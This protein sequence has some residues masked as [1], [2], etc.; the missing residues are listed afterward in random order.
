L[1]AP[2]A[3]LF[4]VVRGIS[5][6]EKIVAGLLVSAGAFAILALSAGGTGLAHPGWLVAYYLVVTTGELLLS[7][8]GLSLVSKLSPPRWIGVLFG[9]W[10]VSTAFGNWLAGLVGRLWAVWSHARFFGGLALLLGV[11]A[12]LLATQL[13][14]L[15][16]TLP[17]DR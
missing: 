5:S 10:F 7:P 11:T 8:V 14:W 3:A 9:L 4:R 2:L 6:A 17:Q 1:S 12:L 13:G 15:R 16:R